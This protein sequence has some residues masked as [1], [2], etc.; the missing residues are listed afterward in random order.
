MKLVFLFSICSTLIL[1]SLSS[2]A[3]EVEFSIAPGVEKAREVFFQKKKERPYF[4][5]WRIVVGI[6]RERREIDE[7]SRDFKR[8]FPDLQVEWVYSN[9]FYRLLSGH[10]LTRWDTISDLKKIRTEYP[11]AFEMNSDIPFDKFFDE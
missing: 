4:R 7:M 6:T 10:Y 9:P 8:K 1:S 3:Q 2:F 5:A 11:G